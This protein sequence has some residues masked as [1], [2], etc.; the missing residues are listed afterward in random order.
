[1]L[2]YEGELTVV[3]G[4]DAKNVSEEHALDFVVGYTAGN[5]V[6]ARKLPATRCI[7]WTILLREVDGWVRA[8]GTCHNLQGIDS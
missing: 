6:S 1:M 4:K 5:D 2:D 3:M 8:G 7:R